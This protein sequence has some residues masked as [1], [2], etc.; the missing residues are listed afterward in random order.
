MGCRPLV[1]FT[2]AGLT[3]VLNIVQS[4]RQFIGL[5]FNEIS[6]FPGPPKVYCTTRN[7]LGSVVCGAWSGVLDFDVG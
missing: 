4:P 1:V 5:N 7:S 2:G 6:G 3:S